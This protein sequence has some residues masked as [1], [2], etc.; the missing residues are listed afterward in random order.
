M[1]SV[2][3]VALVYLLVVLLSVTTPI[4]TGQGVH[5]D[6]LVD[7]ILPHTHYHQATP[8]TPPQPLRHD[9]SAQTSVG[10]DGGADDGSLGVGL[11]PTLPLGAGALQPMVPPG[12]WLADVQPL[13]GAWFDAPPDPP[14]TTS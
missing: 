6:Q 4:G 5:R 14:P 3:G 1:R 10:A 9:E 2:I 8:A 12:R 7:L 11:T 13:P